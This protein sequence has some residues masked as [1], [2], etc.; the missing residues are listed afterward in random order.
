MLAVLGKERDPQ[1]LALRAADFS[2][3]WP[4]TEIVPVNG[5]RPVDGV[6]DFAAS[7][8]YQARQ[9]ENLSLAGAERVLDN[10]AVV[11]CGSG[12]VRSSMCKS[13]IRER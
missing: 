5:V 13:F 9:P 4:A 7:R 6:E 10:I 2:A 1:R 8:A 3:R 12:T 11:R